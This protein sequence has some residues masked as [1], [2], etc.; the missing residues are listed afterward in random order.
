MARYGELWAARLQLLRPGNALMAAAAVVVGIVVVEPE[1]LPLAAWIGAP[2]AAFLVTGFGNI[3]NDVAD[4]ETDRRAHPERPLPSGRI[5]RGEA[6]GFAILLLGLGLWEAFVAGGLLLALFAAL[7]AAL[8]GVYEWK[9]KARGLAGNVAVGLLVGSTFV[10]GAT[11]G[12]GMLPGWGVAWLVALLAAGTNVARELLKD[13]E[14]VEA[15]RDVRR[16]FPMAAGRRATQAL[17]SGLTV[18]AVIASAAAV[19]MAPGWWPNWWIVLGAAN[20][21]MLAGAGLAWWHP[22]QGQRLLKA[23]MLGA[24]LAFL[25]GPLAPGIVGT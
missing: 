20:A 24:I 15:D 9:L 16:T 22:G 14:D 18:A 1:T 13:L 6:L 25:A 7:N 4:L 19:G 3:L 10:F 2:L 5:D 21:V 11:A 17:A 8:L 23:G 12:A